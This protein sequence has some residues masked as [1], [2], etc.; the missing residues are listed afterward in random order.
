MQGV[1][2]VLRG[3]SVRDARGGVLVL[4]EIVIGAASAAVNRAIVS[5]QVA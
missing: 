4:D 1:N 2:A 3:G 5:Q